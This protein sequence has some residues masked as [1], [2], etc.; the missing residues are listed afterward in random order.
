LK[1]ER[2]RRTPALQIEVLILLVPSVPLFEILGPYGG[3]AKRVE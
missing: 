3:V 1:R 2:I